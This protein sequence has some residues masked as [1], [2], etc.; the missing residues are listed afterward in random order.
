MIWLHGIPGAGKTFLATTVIEDIK[1]SLLQDSGQVVA[2][3]YFSFSDGLKQDVNAALRSII[4]QLTWQLVAIPGELKATYEDLR[5]RS[6]AS[7]NDALLVML[8]SVISQFSHTYL[9]LDA[10]D[11]CTERVALFEAI[12][13]IDE[14]KLDCISIFAASRKEH[15]VKEALTNLKLS[16]DIIAAE[17]RLVDKDIESFVVEKLAKTKALKKWER[18]PDLRREIIKTLMEKSFGMYVKLH[19][20]HH[21]CQQLPSTRLHAAFNLN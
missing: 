9:I 16:T 11:E 12:Q 5:E 2:Y 13:T 15:D 4:H 20:D 1:E 8:K 14:W 6:S 7:S 21:S 19:T 18:K 17:S 10:L 3:F